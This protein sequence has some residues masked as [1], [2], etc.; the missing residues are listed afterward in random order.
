MRISF[1]KM[2]DPESKDGM[3]INYAPAKR[4]VSR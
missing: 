3:K 4:K 2:G 1:G